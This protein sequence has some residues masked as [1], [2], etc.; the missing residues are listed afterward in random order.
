[1]PDGRD[2]QGAHREVQGVP[3]PS[4]FYGTAWKEERTAALTLQALRRGFRA[5]DTANQRRHYLE[6]GV[7]EAVAEA[8]DT[9]LVTRAS[10]FLQTKFTFQAGQDHRLPYDPRAPIAD[11]VRQSFDVSL[12]HLRTPFLDALVLHGPSGG[13][14]LQDEDWEAWRA[15]EELQRAGKTRLIGASNV[16]LDQLRLLVAEAGVRPAFVQNRCFAR[17]GW[18]RAVRSFCA[19]N[20]IGYQG[21]SLL[22]ANVRELQSPA[23]RGVVQRTGATLAQVVFA[24][25]LAVGMFPLT[26]TTSESHMGEDLDAAGIRLA[27]E[28]VSALERCAG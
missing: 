26:G 27:P 25:A 20:G 7:G 18:D 8:T 3:V 1:M 2:V 17:A 11:Q 10:L 19:R 23:V 28:D 9:G 14:G 21:F 22:T 16:S 24:F 6:A 13:S 12:E 5:I 15:M 4:F